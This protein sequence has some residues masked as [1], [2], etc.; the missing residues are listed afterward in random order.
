MWLAC[1]VGQQASGAEG[2]SG[3]LLRQ[4][5]QSLR[6]V[7][8]PPAADRLARDPE[9]VRDVGFGEAQFAAAQGAQAKRLKDV[10]GQHAGVG[11][12]DGHDLFSSPLHAIA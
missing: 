7:G 9:Q 10:I 5:V 4:G 2:A 3:P 1:S 11:Q 6:G 8:R 12:G